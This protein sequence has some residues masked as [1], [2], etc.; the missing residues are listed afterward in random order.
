MNYP[1]QS[2]ILQSL[3][4]PSWLLRL[5]GHESALVYIYLGYAYVSLFILPLMWQALA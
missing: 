1:L 2:Y 4:H 5:L 3:H